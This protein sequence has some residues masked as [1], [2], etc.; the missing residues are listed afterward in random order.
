M[1]RDDQRDELIQTD[2]M[3]ITFYWSKDQVY[4]DRSDVYACKKS[5]DQIDHHTSW[6]QIPWIFSS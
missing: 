2:S 1:K 4:V 6:K 3:I 5:L